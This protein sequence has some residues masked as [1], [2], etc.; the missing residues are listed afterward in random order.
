MSSFRI[1]SKTEHREFLVLQNC[2]KS[3]Y[4]GKNRSIAPSHFIKSEKVILDVMYNKKAYQRLNRT[5]NGS[6]KELE[7]NELCD[8]IEKSFCQIVTHCEDKYPLDLLNSP[9]HSESEKY[10]SSWFKNAENKP[11]KRFRSKP[12]ELPAP[13]KCP[14][15]NCS[16]S[17]TAKTGVSLHIRRVHNANDIF[18]DDNPNF[19]M[20]REKYADTS[21]RFK[22]FEFWKLRNK[23]V[24]PCTVLDRRWLK[25]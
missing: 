6:M 13:Y 8:R 12:G 24:D 17:Y 9:D 16:K 11:K 4:Y 23:R 22:F 5:K 19:D 21:Y 15:K 7:P 3:V 18:G 20:L 2:L 25:S 1:C 10:E 14:I